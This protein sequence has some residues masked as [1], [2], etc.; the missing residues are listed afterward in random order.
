MSTLNFLAPERQ[1]GET[2]EVYKLRQQQLARHAKSLR[3]GTPG[4]FAPRDT[5]KRAWKEAV[6]ILGRRQALKQMKAD[7]RAKR[8][9]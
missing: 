8:E 9:A 4:L 2:F 3:R 7:R 6:K 1:E 5:F